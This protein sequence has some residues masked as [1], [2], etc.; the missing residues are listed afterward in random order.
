MVQ[1]WIDLSGGNTTGKSR[2]LILPQTDAEYLESLAVVVL[3]PSFLA[4]APGKAPTPIL[5][6]SSHNDGVNPR[7]DDLTP[8]SNGYSTISKIAEHVVL[9]SL[10]MV[11]HHDKYGVTDI[12][13]ID[14]TIFV[15]DASNAFYRLP[16]SPKLVSV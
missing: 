9:T 15:A 5:N 13:D 3:S 16:N 7:M 6:L 11:Q 2:V 1:R 4:Y 8:D 12:I 10:D 14:L